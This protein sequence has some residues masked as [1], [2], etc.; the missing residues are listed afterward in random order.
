MHT[1]SV[2]CISVG[3]HTGSATCISVGMHTGSA[4]CISVGMH[5]GSAIC[6]S[7]GMHTG[8]ATCISVGMHTGSATCKLSF[9]LM[10]QHVL[11]CRLHIRKLTVIEHF[12]I[13]IVIKLS[14]DG[15]V[16]NYGK[17]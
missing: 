16:H 5:T 1:G 6:I 9:I 17:V 8:S 13:I 15:Y 14:C 12:N 11:V 10:V 2:I 7:V 4:T 3:M